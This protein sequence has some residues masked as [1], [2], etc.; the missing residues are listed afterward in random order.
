MR[1]TGAIQKDML[2]QQA[3][4]HEEFAADP[5]SL[6][7]SRVR[8]TQRSFIDVDVALQCRRALRAAATNTGHHV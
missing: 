1:N 5:R 4:Q 6:R 3:L 2:S 8:D 7:E